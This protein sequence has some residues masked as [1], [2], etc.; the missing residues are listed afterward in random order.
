MTLA[1]LRRKLLLKGGGGGVKPLVDPPNCC[2]D[3][4]G[5]VDLREYPGGFDRIEGGVGLYEGSGCFDRV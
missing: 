1:I 2:F 4:I 5:T 3:M